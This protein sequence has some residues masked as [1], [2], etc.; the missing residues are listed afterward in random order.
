MPER[1]P[2]FRQSRLGGTNIEIR[3][4]KQIQISKDK[5]PQTHHALGVVKIRFFCHCDI[6]ILVIVSYFA[7]PVKTAFHLTGVLRI[8]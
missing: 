2:L 3:N 1:K 5:M 6:G 7:C 8:S 4:P